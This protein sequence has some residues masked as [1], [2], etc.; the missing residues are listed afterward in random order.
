MYFNVVKFEISHQN[1][2]VNFTYYI[3]VIRLEDDSLLWPK[4]VTI[5]YFL[6]I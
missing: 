3:L 2:A 4:R 5:L 6:N 1:T